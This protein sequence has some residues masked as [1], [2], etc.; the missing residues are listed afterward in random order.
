MSRRE[1]IAL[2]AHL[3]R[4]AGFG[5]T[6]DELE[7]LVEQGYEE[8]VEQL[9]S[10]PDDLLRADQDILFRYIPSTETGGPNPIPGAAQWLYHM[11]NTE[12][13]LEEKMAL[14]WHNIF[15]TGNSKVDNDNH[16][17]AQ[18]HLFR[19]HGMGNYRELLIRVAQNPAMIFW[20]DNN[21]NHKRAPN[22]NWGRELLELFSLGVSHYTETDVFE[23]ARA[24]TGW[25]IGAKIPRQPHHR[26]SWNFEFRPEEHDYGQKTFLGHTG[27]FDGEDIIDIILQ[28][29][30][31]PRFIVRH[32]YNF[33]V[34]DEPQVPAW[35]VEPPR[36]PEAVEV[37]AETFVESGY[38]IRPVLR[39]MF[40]SDFFKESMY[41]KV[42]SPVEVVVGTLR[43]VGDLQ[44][45]DPRLLDMGQ[46]P[47]YMGQSLHDPPSVEGWHTGR[48]WINSGSVVKRINFVVDRVSDTDLPG[49]QSIV[50]R[51]ANGDQAMTPAAFVDRCLEYMGPV[52]VSEQTREELVSHAEDE[53]PVSWASDEDY[54]TSSGRVS[55]MLSLIAATTEYQFG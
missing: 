46:E 43:M 32:L 14:F 34:A 45:P 27:N 1:D 44:G 15:A 55:D 3:M 26:F 28:Q 36:N 31:C 22:E 4:R 18:T 35:S 10:P 30:A 5:A 23:C 21:E 9:I 38:E 40:N 2:M 50:D 24:F 37:L 11:I 8:T 48:E 52:D 17:T 33:F 6:R 42:K 54:A 41:Q 29:P 51:V 25:T 39:T 7:R 49:V 20:L 19:N 47:A 12:R 16:L 53:G 13:P